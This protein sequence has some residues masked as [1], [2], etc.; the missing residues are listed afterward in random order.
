MRKECEAARKKWNE[1]GDTKAMTDFYRL[2]S[3]AEKIGKLKKT[4]S[5]WK[6][7]VEDVLN[8]KREPPREKQLLK[9][10]DGRLRHKLPSKL[11][12][13]RDRFG[14]KKSPANRDGSPYCFQRNG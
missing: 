5:Q 11:R 14:I 3:E 1:K 10:N 12:A 7:L 13:R 6:Q 4:A 9:K 2:G 8:K